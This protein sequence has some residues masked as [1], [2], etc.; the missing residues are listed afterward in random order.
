MDT[1]KLVLP[2]LFFMPVDFKQACYSVP[3]GPDHRKKLLFIW[4]DHYQLTSLPHGLTSAPRLFT[5]L[6]KPALK[7]LTT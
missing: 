1:I 5:K 7:H 3:A 6:L 2:E 4:N